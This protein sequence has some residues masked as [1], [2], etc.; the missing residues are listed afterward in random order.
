[1]ASQLPR[2]VTFTADDD[3]SFHLRRWDIDDAIGDVI[4]MHGIIS[5]SGWYLQT[6][7]HLA[8]A[9]F[10]V[11]SLDRRGS[12]LN[13]E[14]RGDVSSC[15]RWVDDVVQYIAAI[16][17]AQMRENKRPRPIILVGISWGGLL[18]TAVAKQLAGD[19]AGLVLLCPG[20]FSRKGT[21]QVQHNA[22]KL[23]TAAGLGGLRFPV[24]LR[25]PELFT[26]SAGWRAYIADDPFT[27]RRVTLRLATASAKLYH[28]TIKTP[29]AIST[30]TLLMLGGRD[31]IIRNDEVGQFVRRYFGQQP[32]VIEYSNAA[33][34]L[35]F[36]DDTAEYLADLA[37]WC[38]QRAKTV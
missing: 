13:L 7:S 19:V 12:G 8:G 2:I 17:A 1:M 35:E 18:A 28:D 9:G 24:P 10:Q 38:G 14:D 21:S 22:V 29:V 31:L 4:V 15:Q 3:Y 5:H 32:K 20:F 34:T 30:P 27:L 37:D 25:D 23:A 16:R 36:E 26:R 33:H 11:H 6:G